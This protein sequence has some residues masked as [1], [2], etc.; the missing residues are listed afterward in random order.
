MKDLYTILTPH[1]PLR[2]RQL[3]DLEFL[4]LVMFPWC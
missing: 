2:L 3:P 4:L 1:L